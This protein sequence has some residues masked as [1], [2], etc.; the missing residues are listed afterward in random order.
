MLSRTQKSTAVRE[1]NRGKS[2]AQIALF[3]GHG[4]RAADLET[5]FKER[6]GYP[7]KIILRQ[8]ENAMP[9]GTPRHGTARKVAPKPQGGDNRPY[10]ARVRSVTLVKMPWEQG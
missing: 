5:Y 8:P 10:V 9:P 1:H 2:L 4:V 7:G 3:I 6:K